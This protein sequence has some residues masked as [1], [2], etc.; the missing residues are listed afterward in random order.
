MPR[1]NRFEESEMHRERRSERILVV[2]RIFEPGR[3]AQAVLEE[4]YERLVPSGVWI[5]RQINKTE[6][7]V[8]ETWHETATSRA[9][10]TGVE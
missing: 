2:R 3:I 8:E 4:A 5:V 9:L 10:C 7:E 1:G 6:P